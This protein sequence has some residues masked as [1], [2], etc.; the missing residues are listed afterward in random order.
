[1]GEGIKAMVRTIVNPMV[2]EMRYYN[3]AF[4]HSPFETP[5]RHKDTGTV[6]RSCFDLSSLSSRDRC[7]ETRSIARSDYETYKREVTLSRVKNR[8]FLMALEAD[9]DFYDYALEWLANR[10]PKG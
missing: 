7:T 3:P 9:A 1:M 4:G 5:L 8:I 2:R 10:I 6:L